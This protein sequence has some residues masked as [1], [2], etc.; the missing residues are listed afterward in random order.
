MRSAVSRPAPGHPAGG[1]LG[2]LMPSPMSAPKEKTTM[3]PSWKIAAPSPTAVVLYELSVL[4]EVRSDGRC[5]I[6]A[7][8]HYLLSSGKALGASQAEGLVHP[9]V[10]VG[11][12]KPPCVE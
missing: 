11:P 6:K 3:R 5:R 12:Q 1:T 8:L 9:E 10:V 2:I 7:T 4:L